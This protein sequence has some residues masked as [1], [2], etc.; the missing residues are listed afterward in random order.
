[1]TRVAPGWYP[2]G[3]QV[4]NLIFPWI[5]TGST[6]TVRSLFNTFYIQLWFID[7]MNTIKAKF[8]WRMVTIN[9]FFTWP[10][11]FMYQTKIMSTTRVAPGWYP[12]GTR[13]V[14]KISGVV[15]DFG[16]YTREFHSK[17]FC[18]FFGHSITSKESSNKILRYNTLSILKSV[19]DNS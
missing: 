16:S 12:G 3:P 6:Q 5:I 4:V 14:S 9:L 2:G 1:M 19:N 10:G 15:R 8:W 11:Y 17:F 7:F 18:K 13:V